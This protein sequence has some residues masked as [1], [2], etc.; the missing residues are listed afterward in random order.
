MS[1]QRDGTG[2]GTIQDNLVSSVEMWRIP[3][4]Q[5]TGRVLEES[6]S[7]GFEFLYLIVH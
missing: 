3:F 4:H 7:K 5:K 6:H 1:R 2:T